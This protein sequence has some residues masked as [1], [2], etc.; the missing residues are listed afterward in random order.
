MGVGRNKARDCFGER[1][2]NGMYACKTASETTLHGGRRGM[3]CRELAV[4]ESPHGMGPRAKATQLS[5]TVRRGSATQAR[6]ELSGSRW[7][8][9]VGDKCSPKSET[10]DGTLELKVDTHAVQNI[11]RC[12]GSTI[13][14]RRSRHG[15]YAQSINACKPI[16]GRLGAS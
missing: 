1:S 2:T 8:I 13:D 3:A 10:V 15:K 11:E 16:K 6:S 14:V 7:C 9:R 12:D 4:R 5:G